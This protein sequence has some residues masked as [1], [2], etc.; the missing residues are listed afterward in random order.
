MK[1]LTSIALTIS[2]LILLPLLAGAEGL[3]SITVGVGQAADPG[4]TSTALQI[5]LVLTVLSMAP[6][7]LL[8][9][10]AFIRIVVVYS[11]DATESDHH[12]FGAIFNLFCHG[13]GLYAGQRKRPATISRQKD[14]PGTGPE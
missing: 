13:A 14:Q 1:R 10:T 3:P 12:R 5:L 7:I 6:A 8:M 9:T 11:T 2:L 4:Q